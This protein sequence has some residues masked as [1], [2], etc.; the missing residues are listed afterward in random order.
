[1]K[2]NIM[3][4]DDNKID[5]FVSQK[6]I[7]KTIDECSIRT[8]I[9]ASSAIKFLKI[10]DVENSYKTLSIPDII[11][12]DINMPE[13]NGFQFL[14]EFNK[15][16]NIKERPI[17]IYI[18]SSSTNLQDV[19]KAKNES[20]CVDFISKPLITRDLNKIVNNYIIY[21]DKYNNLSTGVLRK[22]P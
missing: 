16:K 18:L 20:S 7:K 22:T 5:L 2:L 13:M 1:M 17:K 12:L 3:L 4:I 9:S 19:I 15:L 11:F 8:F 10:L 21:S 14:Q 6:I